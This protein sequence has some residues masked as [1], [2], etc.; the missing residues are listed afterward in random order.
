MRPSAPHLPRPQGPHSA[1]RRMIAYLEALL[2][3]LRSTRVKVR[4]WPRPGFESVRI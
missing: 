2:Q 4:L 1:L 3:R